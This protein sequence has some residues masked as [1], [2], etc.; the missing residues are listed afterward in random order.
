MVTLFCSNK[1]SSG[2]SVP[3][4]TT[5]TAAQEKLLSY[6]KEGNN[7]YDFWRLVD[8]KL[9]CGWCMRKLLFNKKVK[10]ID[11]INYENA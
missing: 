10:K 5:E 9:T 1:C 11:L 4:A 3:S 8:G 2:V 6:A 7:V